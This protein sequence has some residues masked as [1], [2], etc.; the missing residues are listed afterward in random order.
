M[1]RIILSPDD[2]SLVTKNYNDLIAQAKKF[3]DYAF[4]NRGKE[5]FP[6]L[7][8]DVQKIID[9]INKA[10]YESSKRVPY[11]LA[12]AMK[13][14]Y[15]DGKNKPISRTI[16]KEEVT[17]FLGQIE[18]DFK[19]Y[20][21]TPQYEMGLRIYLG[22]DPSIKP[23]P[24]DDEFRIVVVPAYGPTPDD[25]TAKRDQTQFEEIKLFARNPAA[26]FFALIP[27]TGFRH[28]SLPLCRGLIL[29][30]TGTNDSEFVYLP[31]SDFT[32]FL[33]K[34]EGEEYDE[35]EFA[36]ARELVENPVTN[37]KMLT[38]VI[39]AIKEGDPVRTIFTDP[40]TGVKEYGFFMDKNDIIPPPPPP[41]GVNLDSH[42]PRP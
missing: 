22:I 39:A 41:S 29:N 23:T 20:T 38:V 30:K 24:D 11:M 27:S 14:M 17:N 6:T 42:F 26:K 33:N 34:L 32:S 31:L 13:S 5:I 9:T 18:K 25:V 35:V 4:D 28:D 10:F 1:P 7:H 40:S 21:T 2:T 12:Q 19:N 37:N 15:D 36:F 8:N 16:S 3:K